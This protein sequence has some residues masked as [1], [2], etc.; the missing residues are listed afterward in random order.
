VEVS[1]V[2]VE[3]P[4]PKDFIAAYAG[5]DAQPDKHLMVKVG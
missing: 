2:G 1:W 3:N 4:G 5:K